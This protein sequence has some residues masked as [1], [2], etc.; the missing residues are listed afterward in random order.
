LRDFLGD[1]SQPI[2]SGDQRGVQG[3]RDGRCRRWR[4]C[5]HGATAAFDDRLGQLLDEERDAVGAL[6]D[7]VEGLAGETGI[8]GEPLDQCCALMLAEAVQHQC[9]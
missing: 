2:D 6:D 7:R 5:R 8:V 1:R 3:N 9:C 4:R